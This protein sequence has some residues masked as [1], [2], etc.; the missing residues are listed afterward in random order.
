M[1]VRTRFIDAT[2]F[3]LAILAVILGNMVL[4]PL[5]RAQGLVSS[6]LYK[7]RAVGTVSIS[8]DNHHIAYTVVMHDRPGRPYSQVWI[9]DLS[10]GKSARVGGEKEATSG[11]LWSPD[12]KWLGY[13]G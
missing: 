12:G 6:D 11:P 5:C 7:F 1:C 8:P 3:R 10:S 9:M 4:A 2:L 13:S